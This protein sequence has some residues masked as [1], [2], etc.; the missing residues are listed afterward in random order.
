MNDNKITEMKYYMFDWDDNILNMATI[1]HTER[2]VDG[3]WVKHD[4]T[5]SDFRDVRRKIVEYYDNGV[6]EYR[7]PDN[8]PDKAYLE[9]RDFGERGD[10]AFYLDAVR[11]IDGKKFAPAW[12]DLI[13][14]L[15][16]GSLFM[17]I[18]ARGHEPTSIR[19]VIEY[20]IF[21]LEPI[22][23]KTMVDNL[24]QFNSFF[25]V[26]ITNDVD[27]LIENYL[28]LCEFI[29]I[30]SDY[31]KNKFDVV[32]KAIEPETFKSI[33]IEY[34]VSKIYKYRS[35]NYKIQIGFSDD[36]TG[37]VQYVNKF[38]KDELSLKYPMEYFTYDTK[39]GRVK[40]EF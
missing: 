9:F 18:T 40:K 14:C 39:E 35:S 16:D 7:Y 34:F 23:F 24:M 20:I 38:I 21:G 4:V 37:T 8:D 29:G 10:R 30:N 28:D 22:Q 26:N 31:F 5:T 1:I 32:G 3:I 13:E 12:N 2:L 25:N 17:I 6:G 19:K 15:I 27:L 11:S 33:A 36:D